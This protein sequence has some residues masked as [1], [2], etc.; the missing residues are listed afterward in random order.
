M[1]MAVRGF[2]FEVHVGGPEGGAPVLLLHGFPQN[3]GEWDVVAP[4]LHAYGYQTVAP[5]QRGY[6]HGARPAEVGA[7]RIDEPVADALAILDA[8]G[9]GRAHVVGHDWGALVGWHLA[10]R[11]PERVRT[12]TAVSIPHPRAVAAAVAEDPEQRERLSYVALFRQEGKAEEVLLADDAK[13]LRAMFTG[14]PAER[15]DG[16]V[17]PMREPGALTAALNWYRAGNFAESDL[18]QIDVPTTYV[19]GDRDVAIGRAAAG[20]CGDW[21]S[22]AYRFVPLTGFSH[23]LPDEAPAQLAEAVHQQATAE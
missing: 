22:S 23:W 8:R 13:R 11:Y 15:V 19:W 7:Y 17:E 5:D 1:Q 12:F 10:G 2:T 9:I 6:S 18:G 14:C 3:A 16:Y 4:L 20:R 21:V